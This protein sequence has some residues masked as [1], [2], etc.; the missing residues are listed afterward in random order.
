M[1][2]RSNWTPNLSSAI[3]FRLF[4]RELCVVGPTSSAAIM[5]AAIIFG[6]EW[7]VLCRC[8]TVLRPYKAQNPPALRLPK[9]RN[10]SSRFDVGSSD[11]C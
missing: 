8:T 11:L 10:G 7:P 6:R 2:L 5:H 1:R 3:I 4:F 9:R